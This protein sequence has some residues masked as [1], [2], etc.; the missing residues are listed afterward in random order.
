MTL[1]VTASPRAS[2]NWPSPLPCFTSRGAAVL[3]VIAPLLLPQLILADATDWS[4][5]NAEDVTDSNV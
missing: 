1:S 3:A 2:I 4:W 5:A